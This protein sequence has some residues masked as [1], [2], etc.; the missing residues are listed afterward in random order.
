MFDS[1]SF[2]NPTPLAHAKDSRDVLPRGG[3]S[4]GGHFKMS[5][6]IAGRPTNFEPRSSDE[7]GARNEILFPNYHTTP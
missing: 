1:S 3:T 2:V 6:S 7:D 5:W 4:Q